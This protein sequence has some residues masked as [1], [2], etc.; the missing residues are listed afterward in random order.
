MKTNQ[1]VYRSFLFILI[2]GVAAFAAK[3]DKDHNYSILDH[4]SIDIDGSTLVLTSKYDDDEYVEITRSYELYI[5]GREI[6]LSRSQR[7]LVAEYYDQFFDIIDSAREI[8][9]EGARIGVLGAKLGIKAV[10]GAVRAIFSEY[11]ME[12]LEEDLEWES[13]ELEELAEELEEKAEEI[14]EMAEDFEELH[15]ELREEIEE[16]DRLRWF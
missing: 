15:Y 3:K 5:N 16:L 12:E 1:H 9:K 6:D 11:E 7:R 8:G 2:F 14:E 10:K 4:V 13:E